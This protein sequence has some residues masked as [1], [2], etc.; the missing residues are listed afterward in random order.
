MEV[1]FWLLKGLAPSDWH[2]KQSADFVWRKKDERELSPNRLSNIYIVLPLEICQNSGKSAQ[3][4][5]LQKKQIPLVSLRSGSINFILKILLQDDSRPVVI[6]S[7]LKAPEIPTPSTPGKARGGPWH[8]GSWVTLWWMAKWWN[9]EVLWH[10][11]P[12]EQIVWLPLRRTECITFTTSG[13]GKMSAWC[14]KIAAS[15]ARCWPLF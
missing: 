3:A 9:T 14:S 13:L 4:S 8:A 10:L 11:P 6:I 5:S 1:L 2:R 15:S 7:W 12:P